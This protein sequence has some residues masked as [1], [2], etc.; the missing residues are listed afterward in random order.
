MT[1]SNESVLEHAT[2]Q[3]HLRHLQSWLNDVKQL[4]VRSNVVRD[5]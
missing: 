3:E 2:T 1:G 5:S 4:Q